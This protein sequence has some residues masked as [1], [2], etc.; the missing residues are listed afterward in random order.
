MMKLIGTRP[1][2]FST[3][4]PSAGFGR[5]PLNCA[6]AGKPPASVAAEVRRKSRRER[7]F[8]LHLMMH[9]LR[10]LTDRPKTPGFRDESKHM[11]QPL[12]QGTG[13]QVVLGR[14]D[15]RMSFVVIQAIRSK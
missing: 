4:T 9:R 11:C 10:L 2:G 8:I 14:H 3:L 1:R 6:N 5:S 15:Q 13:L 12:T 7:G